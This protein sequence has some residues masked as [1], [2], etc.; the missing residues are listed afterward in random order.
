MMVGRPLLT[1]SGWLRTAERRSE[2]ARIG[3]TWIG[4]TPVAVLGG[5]LSLP[6]S[7]GETLLLLFWGQRQ[8]S[9]SI[10]TP[11]RQECRRSKCL[12]IS[13]PGD[14]SVAD[15]KRIP[16]LASR[17][18]HLNLHAPKVKPLM[19]NRLKRKSAKICAFPAKIT[20]TST[21]SA[22][23]LGAWLVRIWRLWLLY[24][25]GRPPSDSTPGD[26]GSATLLSP[27]PAGTLFTAV[28]GTATGSRH[29]N[30]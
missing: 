15:P 26:V 3:D 18:P 6:P 8:G 5:N 14:K 24:S 20:L 28:L 4:D 30:S 29:S 11:R 21:S 10:S 7:S 12:S 22:Q 19:K 16:P 23:V 2:S 9:P 13:T 25:G 17:I 1:E 27:F